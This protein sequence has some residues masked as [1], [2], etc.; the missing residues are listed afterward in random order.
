MDEIRVTD[1]YGTKYIFR[2]SELYKIVDGKEILVKSKEDK[3][4]ADKDVG[5]RPR[6]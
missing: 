3:D 4:E 1:E 5:N 2:G 6:K